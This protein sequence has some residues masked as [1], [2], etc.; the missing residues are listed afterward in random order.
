MTTN[1]ENNPIKYQDLIFKPEFEHLRLNFP[2]GLTWIR[3]LPGL[4]GSAYGWIL[5]ISVLEFPGGRFVHPAS[6]YPN[7]RSVFD[8]AKRWFLQHEPRLL[9]SK[10]N[11][12]G[13]RLWPIKICVFWVV[14]YSEAG[15]HRSRLVLE[16]FN[17]GANGPKG[18]AHEIWR[19]VY[20]KDENG[21]RMCDA[22]HP[23]KGVMICVER[24]KAKSHHAPLDW[25]RVGRLPQ[26]VDG[27][28]EKVGP[29]ERELLCP[30]ERVIREPTVDEQWDY[31]GR[32]ITPE[33]AAR[34]R[35]STQRR[36]K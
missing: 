28:L 33:L 21:L 7:K 30:L 3:I 12:T 36:R 9:C 17:D 13:F 27:L 15:D 4:G 31:L 2:Q 23:E 20:E 34:I 14:E 24:H 8:I 5:P 32:L 25:V 18:L 22:L 19:K 1:S 29:M 26:S 16:S 35:A 6:F 10:V 11:K